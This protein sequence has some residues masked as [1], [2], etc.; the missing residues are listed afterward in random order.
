MHAYC[1]LLAFELRTI[2]A[3]CDEFAELVN[4]ADRSELD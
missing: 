1:Q 4:P 2:L 3:E